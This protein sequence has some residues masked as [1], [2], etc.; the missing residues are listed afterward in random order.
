MTS[1][2]VSSEPAAPAPLVS[3]LIPAARPGRH[4]E[5]ALD[6]VQAQTLSEF[7]LV[8]T[9]DSGGCLR[10]AVEG[11]GD[12]RFHYVANPVRLGLAGNHCRALDLAR[13]SYVAF[14]H[15]D[16]RWRPEH[17][18]RATAVLDREPDVGLVLV[19]GEDVDEDDVVLGLR[20]TSMAPGRQR[21][22]LA[23]FVRIDALMMLPSLS[24]FRRTALDA[25]ARPW[26]DHQIADVTMYLDVASAGWGVWRIDEV[27]ASYR[28]HDGQATASPSFLDARCLLWERYRFADPRYDALRRRAL[29]E[30][31]VERAAAHLRATHGVAA[32]KD[33][34][35]ARTADPAV[36]DGRW[37]M[38]RALS[39][40]PALAR[41]ARG[42]RA[43]FR[44]L[45]STRRPAGLLS[46]R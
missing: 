31:L 10:A 33:L 42:S 11:R 15:D 44:R 37:H 18:A 45:L 1:P 21:D 9:D 35:A 5:M 14:L 29:A 19:D 24:V 40:T 41:L 38:L 2:S 36:V 13:G 26:P 32:R 27:L 43:R 46:R 6:S 30:A 25:N 8:V 22:P 12:P 7:E 39:A 28:V 17:L 23:E 20:P 4:L 16:D 34:L 3:V